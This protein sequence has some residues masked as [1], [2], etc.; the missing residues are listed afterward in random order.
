[1][2][3]DSEC[4]EEF[5]AIANSKSQASEVIR[6]WLGTIAKN[7]PIPGLGVNLFHS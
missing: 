1:M 2:T 4:S 3:D 5:D 7:L 6:W